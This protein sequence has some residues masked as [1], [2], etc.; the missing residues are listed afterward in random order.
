MT[1]LTREENKAVIRPAGDTIVAANAPALRTALRAMLAEGVTDL[2]VDLDR[3]H[4]VDSSGIGLLISVHNSLRKT[5]GHLSLIHVSAEL[6]EL[7]GIMRITQHFSV[8]GVG[9]D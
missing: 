4:M 1:V 2:V 8:S 3:V 7:F 6:V 9:N 5:G